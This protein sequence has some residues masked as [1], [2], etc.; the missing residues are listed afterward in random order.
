VVPPARADGTTALMGCRP[1]EP[2]RP[3]AATAATCQLPR[4]S[5]AT[6]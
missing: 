2:S 6:R 5:R 1:I 3:S 4:R